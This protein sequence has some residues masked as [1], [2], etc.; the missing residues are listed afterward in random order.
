[1]DGIALTVAV[2]LSRG[3]Q[4]SEKQDGKTIERGKPGMEES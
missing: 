3:F 2:Q 1:M 4:D